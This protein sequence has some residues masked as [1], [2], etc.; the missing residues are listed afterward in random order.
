M[1]RIKEELACLRV[2]FTL[3]VAVDVSVLGWLAQNYRVAH[4]PILGAAA[5][6]AVIQ[7]LIAIVTGHAV[8]TRLQAMER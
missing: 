3:S 7:T 5:I 8:L 6:V 1:E 4:W 2:V